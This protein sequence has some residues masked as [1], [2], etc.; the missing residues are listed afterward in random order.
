M[1]AVL[2]AAEIHQ[3]THHVLDLVGMARQ[4]N[5]SYRYLV[6]VGGIVMFSHRPV[7]IVLRDFG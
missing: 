3:V 1:K 7:G 6:E 5:G 4:S 2:D